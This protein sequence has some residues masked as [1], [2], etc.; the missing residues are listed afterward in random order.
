MD[1]T[2]ALAP[3]LN[4]AC[5]QPRLSYCQAIGRRRASPIDAIC[6]PIVSTAIIIAL[7]LARPS[8]NADERRHDADEALGHDFDDVR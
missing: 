3:L 4:S 6:L 8:S 7:R 1:D 2:R 5:R